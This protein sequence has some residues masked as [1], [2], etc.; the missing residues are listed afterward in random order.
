ML[1]VHF[2]AALIGAVVL[3]ATASAFA[4]TPPAS[5]PSSSPAPAPSPTATPTPPWTFSGFFD[6]T[7]VAP[8]PSGG[9]LLFSN[10]TNARVFDFQAD[11]LVPN[12]FNFNLKRNATHGLGGNLEISTGSDANV[13]A[14]YG[15]SGFGPTG[16]QVDVTQGYLYY[17]TGPWTLDVGKFETLVGAEVIESPSDYEISRSILMGY[18]EPFTHTGV[19]LVYAPTSKLSLTGGV[20]YGW[21]T[22]KSVNGL[23]TL[24]AQVA[25]TPTSAYSLL[26]S[27][28]GG[29]TPSQGYLIPQPTGYRSLVDVVGKLVASS[30]LTFEVNYDGGYQA[31]AIVNTAGLPTGSASWNGIAGYAIYTMNSHWQLSGRYETFHDAQGYKTGIPQTWNEGTATLQF[32]PQAANWKLRTEY[33]FDTSNGCTIVASGAC[34]P[35]V[36][37]R[38]TLPTGTVS[39]NNSSIGLEAIYTWP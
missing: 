23:S 35:G 18:A 20:N 32:T 30:A 28:L 33:R 5:S 29:T 6:A 34:T 37:A 9:T 4:Q 11:R 1:R 38:Y 24:E 14:S 36:F 2:T 16:N 3:A 25:W 27:Y 26:V 7:Y 19:R 21:D 17:A 15:G 31:N 10:G 39:K 13:I 12:N 8:L 22:M